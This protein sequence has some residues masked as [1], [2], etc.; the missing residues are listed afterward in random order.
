MLFYFLCVMTCLSLTLRKKLKTFQKMFQCP[1]WMRKN[2]IP[3]NF[4]WRIAAETWNASCFK[5][6]LLEKQLEWREWPSGLRRCDQN[7]KV[8]GSNPTRRL[9]G[10]WDPTMHEAP[11]DPRVEYVKRKWLTLG[12]WDCLLDN[13]PKLAVGQPNS[14]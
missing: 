4:S 10:L 13:G 1:G 9:A 7:G 14:S 2:F 8:S 6:G 3:G 5:K 12:E 11:G